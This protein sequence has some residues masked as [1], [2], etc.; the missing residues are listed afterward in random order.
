MGSMFRQIDKMWHIYGCALLT[1]IFKVLMEIIYPYGGA[2]N[3]MI[4]SVLT[5]F[6][7]GIKELVDFICKTGTASKK[8]LYADCI[9]TFSVALPLM[10]I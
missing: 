5:L 6:L 8:D 3:T 1:V 2:V 9:G 10:F 7:A 4:A